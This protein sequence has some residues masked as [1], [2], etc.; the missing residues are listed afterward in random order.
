MKKT[1][2]ALLLLLSS[3]L[4]AGCYFDNSKRDMDL[5][6]VKVYDLEGN[7]II[8]EFKNYYREIQNQESKRLNLKIQKLNSAAPIINYYYLEVEDNSSFNVDFIFSS[9]NK[10]EMKYLFIRNLVDKSDILCDNITIHDD[11]IIV[12]C[13][14]E[15]I[16]QDYSS[17]KIIRW[18]DN[19]DRSHFFSDKGGN[20]YNRGVYFYIKNTNIEV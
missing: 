6:D 13:K 9:K 18:T 5:I 1:F 19:D 4:L 17:F 10:K 15:N 11:K 12:T 20:T 16:R 8:G 2:F 14:F 3:I 7:E